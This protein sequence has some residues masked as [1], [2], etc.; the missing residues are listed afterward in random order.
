MLQ[1]KDIDSYTDDDDG[2][3]FPPSGS[4]KYIIYIV[5]HYYNVMYDNIYTISCIF[6][7]EQGLQEV[8]IMMSIPKDQ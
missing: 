1:E 7:L 2:D 3:G 8:A 5:L 6:Q 4:M